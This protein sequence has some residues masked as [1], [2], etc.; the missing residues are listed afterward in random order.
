MRWITFALFLSLTGSAAA[1]DAAALEKRW[2]AI[3]SLQA[4]FVQVQRDVDG[5]LL[6]E[7]S[8]RMA[9]ERPGRFRWV[10][11]APYEQT[12]VADGSVVWVHEPD[13][14]QVSRRPAQAAMAGTPAELLAGE[15]SLAE[16]FTVQPLPPENGAQGWRLE[17]RKR[18]AEFDRID[19]WF[20][21]D[22]PVRLVFSDPLG[23]STEVRLISPQLNARLPRDTFRFSPPRGHEVV[24]LQ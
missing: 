7:S 13:L 10:Y 3:R 16:V 9:L 17:P 22:T 5:L 14:K 20:E 1:Q 6:G 4:E 24:D 21:G 19:L 2:A 8:G 18:D 11:R 23:G 12:I 15:V